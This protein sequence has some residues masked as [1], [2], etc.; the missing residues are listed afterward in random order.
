VRTYLNIAR[1]LWTETK[2]KNGEG[3][4]TSLHKDLACV[5]VTR[6]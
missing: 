5:W 4:V 2:D 3:L 1:V 6:L